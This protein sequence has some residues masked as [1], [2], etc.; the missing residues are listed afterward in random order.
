M[1]SISITKNAAAPSTLV[2]LLPSKKRVM[3]S[4]LL[5]TLALTLVAAA[6]V[7]MP[8]FASQAQAGYP[9]GFLESGDIIKLKTIWGG[10]Y[11]L[12][13][14]GTAGTNAVNTVAK[15]HWNTG[16]DTPNRF[17]VRNVGNILYGF[18]WVML[19]HRFPGARETPE[20]CLAVENLSNLSWVSLQVCNPNDKRQYFAKEGQFYWGQVGNRFRNLA[21]HEIGL[22]TVLTQVQEQVVGTSIRMEFPND[23]GNR[24]QWSAEDCLVNGVEQQ[25]C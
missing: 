9:T 8:Q 13:V 7:Q 14:G 1:K 23:T 24:Q 17:Q 2:S 11:T 25:H 6:T 20:M 5:K 3:R 10:G 18:E 15:I 16:W 19:Q 4:R 12:N 22:N 21:H